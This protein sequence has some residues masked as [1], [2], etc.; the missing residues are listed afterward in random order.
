MSRNMIRFYFK[1][2]LA[3][4]PTPKL[5]PNLV[6][7]PRLL[8]QYIRSYPPYRTP[9]LHPQPKDAP[10][11]GEKDPLITATI[12]INDLIIG[13]GFEI[14][15]IKRGGYLTLPCPTVNT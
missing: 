14:N 5:R 6:G 2:L 15:E 10:C 12:L 8:I 11:H 13:R 4:R 9:F 3:P 1:Q 7:C